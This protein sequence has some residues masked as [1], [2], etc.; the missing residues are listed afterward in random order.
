MGYSESDVDTLINW[1]TSAHPS[2]IGFSSRYNMDNDTSKIP[3][4]VCEVYK[5]YIDNLF[6]RIDIE[7]SHAASHN[8]PL[9]VLL[10]SIDIDVSKIKFIDLDKTPDELG[11]YFMSIGVDVPK[12][13]HS[14]SILGEHMVYELLMKSTNYKLRDILKGEMMAYT[15]LQSYHN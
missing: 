10:N 14:N 13:K 15:I 6:R 4:M 12:N 1:K 5:M 3:E 11:C 2:D 8:L 7:S 9:L